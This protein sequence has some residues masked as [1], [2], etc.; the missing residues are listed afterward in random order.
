MFIYFYFVILSLDGNRD[1]ASKFLAVFPLL[2]KCCEFFLFTK[3]VFD[4]GLVPVIYK[5]L[6]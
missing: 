1:C 6:I 2:S 4:K 5:E 3:Y